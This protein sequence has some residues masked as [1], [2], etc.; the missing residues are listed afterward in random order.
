[1]AE[2]KVLKSEMVFN[3]GH[4]RV[5]VDRVIEPAG[6]EA[7]REIVVHP[8][9]VCIVARPSDDE[10]LLIRQ[11]RHSTGGELL[12]IP[13]GGL[14]PGEDPLDAARRELEEETGF[15]AA[16]LVQRAA[17]WTTPGFTTE[18]MW[19]YEATELTKT[20]IDPDEDEVIEVDRVKVADA[21]RFIEDGTIQDAKTILGL[22]RVFCNP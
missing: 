2:P 7:T 17:F 10:V 6:H 9:A 11:Y 12:E 4:I 18:Y 13:A 15:R 22:L 3:G 14:D 1:M 5:R 20:E 16:K 8:G 19:L 21:M